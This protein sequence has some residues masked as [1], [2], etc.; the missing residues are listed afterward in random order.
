MTSSKVFR[1][2]MTLYTDGLVV[3]VNVGVKEPHTHLEKHINIFFKIVKGI[4]FRGQNYFIILS[5]RPYFFASS[6]AI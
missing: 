1:L 2:R 6:A 5:I 3:S 4:F